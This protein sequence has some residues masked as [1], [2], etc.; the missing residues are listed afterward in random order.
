[1]KQGQHITGLQGVTLVTANPQPLLRFYTELL[2]LRLALEETGSENRRLSFADPPDDGGSISVSVQSDAPPGRVGI[3]AVHHLAFIVETYDA[4]LKWKRRLRDLGVLVAGPY[5]QE[6][7]QDIV[8][9]DPDGVLLE[10]ATRGPGWSATSDGS[11][12]YRPPLNTISPYRDEAAIDA[13]TWIDPVPEI[14]PDMTMRGLHHVA[15]IAS[16]L[17]KTDTFYRDLGLSLLRKVVD[18]DDFEVVQWCWGRE[19][20][21]PGMMVSA[22]PIVHPG[23]GGVPVR[24]QAGIGVVQSITLG[25]DGDSS[26]SAV[27]DPDGIRMQLA[28]GRSPRGT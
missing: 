3:G 7:Y 19:D 1:V 10:L 22:F 13:T 11:D 20:T 24:G 9:T 5:N 27:E 28:P 18:S 6:A 2:G 12:V 4:L 23:E 16:D 17:E 26:P 14:E 25:V 8:L 21:L 15:T